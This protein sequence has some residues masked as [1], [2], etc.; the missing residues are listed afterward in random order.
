MQLQ[1]FSGQMSGSGAMRTLCLAAL[2]VVSVLAGAAMA[3]AQPGDAIEYRN[4]KYG[5]TMRVP[6][7]V[8][9][10]GATKN[11]DAGSLWI[12][13]DK[14]ARLVAAAQINSTG[15][16]IQS[17]RKFLMQENYSDAQIDYSPIKDN[18]F[19]ISGVSKDGQMFY[20]RVT[21]ACSGRYIYGWQ[22]MYPPAERARYDR[23]VEA[24]HRSYR[25][26]QGPDGNCGG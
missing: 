10:P 20:E 25:V 23:I 12:S 3:Q 9:Q 2:A 15:E 6:S 7:D 11:A 22:M 26:G 18:W 24:V 8:F 13:R 5:F 16:S 19:V 14:Q 4:P 17:Y 21:F 1:F